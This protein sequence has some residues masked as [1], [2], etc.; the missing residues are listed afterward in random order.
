MAE[1]DK[2]DPKSGVVGEQPKS[3]AVELAGELG[4]KAL[5]NAS[6]WFDHFETQRDEDIDELY[7][8]GDWMYKGGTAVE[9]YDTAKG[10][11]I[12]RMREG[13]ANL[14][15]VLYHRQVNA[16][17]SLLAQVL[18]SGKELWKYTDKQRKGNEMASETGLATAEMLNRVFAPA[19]FKF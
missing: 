12:A 19:T 15:S 3:K 10:Q 16:R 8:L 17:A 13:K 11:F 2:V 4:K 14:G 5:S 18:L 9:R 6:G 7:A 1:Q